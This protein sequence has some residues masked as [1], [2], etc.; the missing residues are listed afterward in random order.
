LEN[1]NHI[2]SQEEKLSNIVV[3]IK[4]RGNQTELDLFF[5]KKI[6]PI[7]FRMLQEEKSDCMKNKI[8]K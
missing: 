8:D 3:D 2:N 1:K 5:L 6:E 4:D 7:V